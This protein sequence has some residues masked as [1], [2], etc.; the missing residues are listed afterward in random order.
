MVILWFGYATIHNAQCITIIC[1]LFIYR[2][3]CLSLKLPQQGYKYQQHEVVS[4]IL[5]KS[6]RRAGDVW[7][8]VDGTTTLFGLNAGPSPKYPFELYSCFDMCVNVLMFFFHCKLR[9]LL[10]AHFVILFLASL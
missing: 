1:R 8:N 2:H 4:Q 3:R 9:C 10:H 7:S 6:L 5:R